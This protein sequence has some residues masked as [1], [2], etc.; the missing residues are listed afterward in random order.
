MLP[1]AERQLIAGL[2]RTLDAELARLSEMMSHC[3]EL[4]AHTPTTASSAA[5]AREIRDAYTRIRFLSSREDAMKTPVVPGVIC[6]PREIADTAKRVNRAK[7]ALRDACTERGATTVQVP[8]PRGAGTRQV[9]YLRA[10]LQ[11]TELSDLNLKAAYRAIWILPAIPAVVTFTRAT[12]SVVRRTTAAEVVKRYGS[13]TKLSDEERRALNGLPSRTPLALIESSR[14]NTR[15]NV[16][17]DAADGCRRRGC[18]RRRGGSRGAYGEDSAAGGPDDSYRARTVRA[19][20][21][22]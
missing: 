20:V 3:E 12:T 6:V 14:E 22:R 8:A 15:A 1:A 17:F 19:I 16:R 4:A 5:A 7:R 10:L 2:V 18:G 11:Q 13:S 9:S 21:A